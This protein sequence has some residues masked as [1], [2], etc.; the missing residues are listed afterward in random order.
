MTG[1]FH[2]IF[3]LNL[4]THILGR[5]TFR[6]LP[7]FSKYVCFPLVFITGMLFVNC[8]ICS[9]LLHASGRLLNLLYFWTCKIHCW[10]WSR[11]VWYRSVDGNCRTNDWLGGQDLS[12]WLLFLFDNATDEL[13]QRLIIR[14][15]PWKIGGMY[16]LGHVETRA[17][18]EKSSGLLDLR[19][20]G[21]IAWH[22]GSGVV[23]CCTN[24]NE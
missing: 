23:I 1:K 8:C 6:F 3:P 16:R 20:L 21:S 24:I 4:I 11:Y 19:V 10:W 13:L 12:R 22:I 7:L 18:D 15:R 5:P 9:M 2:S 17:G 14:L